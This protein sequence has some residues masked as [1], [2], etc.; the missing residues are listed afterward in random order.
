V[1]DPPPDVLSVPW[2]Y[3]GGVI[4]VTVGAVGAAGA[5]TLRTLRRP[6][7]EELRDL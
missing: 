6:A 7:I 1:F 3:L 4:V 5:L 2:T